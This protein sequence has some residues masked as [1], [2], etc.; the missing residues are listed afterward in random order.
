MTTPAS[1]GVLPLADLSIEEQLARRQ[2]RV[3]EA[4]RRGRIQADVRPIAP[5]PR[6]VGA[7]ARVKL[8][9]GPEGRLGF[10]RPGTHEWVEVPLEE[11]ARP[12]IAAEAARIAGRVRGA[13]ELRSDG[14]RVAVVVE[15]AA[16]LDG[17]VFLGDLSDD[18]GGR[19]RRGR[20]LSGNPTLTIEGLR[21]SPAS[22]YQVNL[23]MN[24][25]IVA[26]VDA[27]LQELAPARLLDLYAGIGNLSARAVRRGVPT[28]LVEN[29][30]SSVADA[31]VNAKGAEIVEADAGRLKAGER[32]FDVLMLD[33]PRAGAQGLLP[34]LA[35][36]RPRAILYLSCEPTTLARDLGPVLAQGYRVERVQ[37]YDM[38]PG[39]EHVET[40]VVLLR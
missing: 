11:V 7:R 16:D 34:R 30:P 20:V 18:A 24:T 33:P 19:R 6:A 37:P 4:L 9:A 35:V 13:C 2:A 28:T 39:T 36:T 26:D 12:E 1:A 14:A 23:E 22:F 3:E 38:F 10:F 15:Q 25:R 21:V 40:L 17:D 32:F 8:R 29:D 5:S 27:L 31:R